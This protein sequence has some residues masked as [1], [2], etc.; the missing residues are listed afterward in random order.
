MLIRKF[1]FFF[2]FSNTFTRLIHLYLLQRSQSVFLKGKWSDSLPLDKGVPQESIFGPLFFSLY[3]NDLP[4]YLLN[5]KIHSY[6]D[7]VQLCLNS[8]VDDISRD[9]DYLKGELARIWATANGLYLNPGKSKCILLHRRSV[10]PT[11][12]K[13]L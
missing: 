3:V 13:E 7:D 9:V 12:P 8:S 1:K 5:C 4:G 10:V 2:R 6:S 11:I